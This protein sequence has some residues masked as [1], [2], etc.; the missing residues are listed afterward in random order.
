M[1]FFDNLKEQVAELNNSLQ[2]S[3]K[4]YKNAKFADAAMA[5]C[6]LIAA[7]D[8]TIDASER[9]KTASYITKSE[10]LAVFD[11]AELQQ[12]FVSYCDKL[13]A[14][15]DFG[16]IEMLQIIGKLRGKEEQARTVIQVAIIIG[17]ADGNF[18]DDEKMAVRD[19]CNTV[20]IN[21]AEFNL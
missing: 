9:K 8:G 15:F 2:S 1:G 20:G 21:P 12:K 16:K 5:A 18:D 17:G 4:K 3:V 14:D 19:I 7:A 10:A 11:V 13:S 6:A